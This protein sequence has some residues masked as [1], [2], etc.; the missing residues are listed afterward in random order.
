MKYFTR[1]WCWGDLDDDQAEKVSKN[2]DRYLDSIRSS[3][4]FALKLLGN[5]INLHDGIVKKVKVFGV[6]KSLGLS[7]I[8]GDLEIG[9]FNLSVEYRN[10]HDLDLDWI[11]GV[12]QRKK[13]E[14]IR[15]E[16][17]VVKSGDVP[18]FFHRLIF[19]NKSEFQICFGDCSFQIESAHQKDYTSRP[20]SLSI[21][22]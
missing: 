22:K 9:Y 18:R 12:F 2:Y 21:L 15:D 7:G 3:L 16:I 13:V 4:P 14:I 11:T 10:I 17:E 8:F 20:C 6:K 19:S 5:N 1:E